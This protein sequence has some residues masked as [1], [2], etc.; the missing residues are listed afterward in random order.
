M[1]DDDKPTIA[2]AVATG[3]SQGDEIVLPEGWW[4]CEQ[5]DERLVMMADIEILFLQGQP[6]SVKSVLRC[7][8]CGV[9]F[10]HFTEDPDPGLFYTSDDVH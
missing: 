4:T 6:V 5:C 8:K 1:V 7:K 10:D 2:K 9:D 3:Y